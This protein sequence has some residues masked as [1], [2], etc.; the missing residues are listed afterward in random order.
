MFKKKIAS[1]FKYILS[2][3][4]LSI[5]KYVR[6]H[7]IFTE[8]NDVSND[9]SEKFISQNSNY[10]PPTVRSATLSCLTFPLNISVQETEI[11]I[12]NSELLF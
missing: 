2:I 7:L 9:I 1:F 10:L 3:I 12:G 4:F 5:K 6:Y 11:T 8:S